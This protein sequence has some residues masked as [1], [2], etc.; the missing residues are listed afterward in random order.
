MKPQD[1]HRSD[2]FLTALSHGIDPSDGQDQLATLFLELRDDVEA[3]MPEAPTLEAPATEELMPVAPMPEDPTVGEPLAGEPFLDESLSDELLDDDL[4]D[5]DVDAAVAPVPLDVERKKRR[6]YRTS[7]WMA[8]L[9]GAAAATVMVA[10]TGAALYN[11]TPDSPLWGPSQKLFGGNTDYVELASTLDEIDSKAEEGDIEGARSLIEQLR[12]SLK[13]ERSDRGDRGNSQRGT[14]STPRPD[15]ETVTVTTERKK[16]DAERP[17]SQPPAP[18]TVTVT[19][20]VTEPAAPANPGTQPAPSNAATQAPAPA[21][22]PAPSS[23]PSGPAPSAA[24]SSPSASSDQ[25]G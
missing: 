5:D 18:D 16:D 1:A 22:A 23:A 7:P 20:V 11:A 4:L 21:P 10:G 17:A 9:V 14:T 15:K 6:S 8:G 19:V 24:P 2:E 13:A 12:S 25:A 3:P